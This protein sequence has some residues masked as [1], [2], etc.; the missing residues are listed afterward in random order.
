VGAATVIVVVVVTVRAGRCGTG[1]DAIGH[2]TPVA[3]VACDR[4]TRPAGDRTPRS[5]RPAYAWT[6]RY[7]M[8]RPGSSGHPHPSA[9]AATTTIP[10]TTAAAT[11]ECIVGNQTGGHE[12]GCRKA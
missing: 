9:S 11:G 7:R 3:G 4:A 5:A 2:A 10:A 12:R 1:G 6:T 8:R